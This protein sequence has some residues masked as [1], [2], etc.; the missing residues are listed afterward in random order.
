[1]TRL[2]ILLK[3]VDS[4]Q[5]ALGIKTTNKSTELDHLLRLSWQKEKFVD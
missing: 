2:D 5:S 1:M 4:M 3:K